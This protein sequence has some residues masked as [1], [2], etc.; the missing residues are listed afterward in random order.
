MKKVY[1]TA[2]CSV[3]L[4]SGCA[5]EDFA[6]L[7]QKISDAAYDVNR[8]VYGGRVTP[9]SVSKTFFCRR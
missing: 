4:L 3:V 2:V 1:L 8:V 9:N 6:A 7:N 5:T